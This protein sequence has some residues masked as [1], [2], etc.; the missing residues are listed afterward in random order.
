MGIFHRKAYEVT[1]TFA[2]TAIGAVAWS[3]QAEALAAS[4]LFPLVFLYQPSRW[5]AYTVALAYYSAANW[6][7][8]RGATT[9]FG[10]RES[11]RQGVMLWLT[12]SVL[13]A[14]PW[15][16]LHFRI[17]AARFWSVPLSLAITTLPPIGL[18]GWASPLTA[19]GILFPGT[20]WLGI[21]A[22][23]FLPGLILRYPYS[24][25]PFATVLIAVT[26]ASY[27]G[28][29]SAPPLWKAINTTFGRSEMELPDPLRELQTARWIQRLAQNS[30]ARVIIF[31]ETVVPRWNESTEAF[32]APTFEHLRASGKTLIFGAAIA[33][34]ESKQYLNVLVIRGQ[35][36]LGHF[37][38][39][40]PVPIAMWKPASHDGFQLR[41]SGPGTID[42]TG[43]RAG[44][45]VCYELLLTWPVLTSALEH[46]TVLIG[47]ANDYWAKQTCIPFVQLAALTAW[48]RLFRL[49]R[50]MAVNT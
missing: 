15:G 27:P 34:P 25:L 47:V 32:W 30:P 36:N 35:Q 4:F 18:I 48:A 31:P 49:P 19:A 44:I 6:P 37:T 11:L 10:P 13:L 50:L 3:G 9:F 41:L 45:L 39:R 46:P 43:H 33:V 12:T 17:W 7:L 29:P 21:A 28:D 1:S 14:A 24:A 16:L 38:Q 42:L 40:I 22:V 26:H 23:L 20:A 5:S 2:A 8:V